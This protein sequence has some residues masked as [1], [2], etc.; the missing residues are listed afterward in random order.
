VLNGHIDVVPAERSEWT[1]DPFEPRWADGRVTARGAADMKGGLLAAVFAARAVADRAAD[2]GIDG[3]IVVEGVAGEEDGGFGAATAA[4]ANPYPFDRDAAL[5]AEPTELD[6]VV[7]AEGSLMARLT[8]HGRSAH[9]ATRWEGESV[10]P[11]F[12]R[13]RRA[14]L[15]L[16][17]GR[18]ERVTHPLYD[19]FETPWPINV[20]RVEAGSWAST[21]PAELTAE[22]RIG[23]APGE[24]VDEVEAAVRERIDAVVAAD[25]WLSAHPPD[26]ERFSVQF[27]GSEI[28]PDEPIA[29]AVRRA[30]RDRG[31]D[32]R[33]V[34][35][36][37]GT[38]ARHYVAAGI[39]TV[40]FGPGSIDQAHQ[41]D[42][43]V[44]WTE[45]LEAAA[46]IAAAAES[47]LRG[48]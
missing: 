33:D 17:R 36:T 2:A 11:R 48:D 20:G 8:V 27:E 30:A 46:I 39:P 43:T 45:V 5:I 37:G 19:E 42:E 32:P 21:V 41:P 47:Y 15:D 28:D 7:A 38:D 13:I 18:G 40:V 26:F 29:A 1:G 10:L 9:A 12:E 6:L 25:D 22:L 31:R 4:A 44:D 35:F 23:V 16:E 34:G 14:L 24:T 3:R